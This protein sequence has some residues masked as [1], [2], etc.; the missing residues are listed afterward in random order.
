MFSHKKDIIRIFESFTDRDFYT[1]IADFFEM[2]AISIRNAVHIGKTRDEYEERYERTR[3]KYTPDQFTMFATALGLLMDDIH[4]S[5]DCGKLCDWCGEIYMESGTSN[6]RLGQ[7]FT[8]YAVSAVTSQ[9][10][11][12]EDDVRAKLDGNPDA[13]FT[14]Y[15]PTCG[16]G[17]MII[18]TIEKL[19][20]MGVNYAHN[21]FVD[22]GDIDSRCV[23]MT[24]LVLSVLGVPAV[25]RKGDALMLKY[26]E[27]WFTPAYVINCAHFLS[28]IGDGSYPYTAVVVKPIAQPPTATTQPTQTQPTQTQTDEHGQYLLNLF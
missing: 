21:I 15:E 10:V 16:A 22:C 3:Q 2:S 6:S 12:R 28:E 11:V 13:V 8:P 27:A 19:M 5:M 25:V 9:S 26:T 7:F 23:H 20:Q 1:V 14:I 18:S 24:Y 4:A 17:G